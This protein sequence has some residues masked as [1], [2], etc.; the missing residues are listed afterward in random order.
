MSALAVVERRTSLEGSASEWP[1]VGR[2]VEAARVAAAVSGVS[3]VGSGS[4]GG[5]VLVGSAG[6][7]KTALA[8]CCLGRAAG[9]GRSTLWL[10]GTCATADIPL[11]ALSTVLTELDGAASP[12]QLLHQASRAVLARASA[13]PLVLAVDDG[14]WLDD[15][16]ATLVAR[17]VDDRQ[18]VLV[19][20]IRAGIAVPDPLTALWKN[21]RVQRIELEPLDRADVDEV[22]A[23]ALGGPVD[24]AT[25]GEFRRVSDGNPLFLRELFLAAQSNGLLRMRDGAWTLT[26]PLPTSG[27]LAEL[28]ETRLA[29]LDEPARE[30]LEL[31][32]VGG[33]LRLNH[34]EGLASLDVLESLETAELL[35]VRQTAG[36]EQVE[37]AHPLFGE[38]LRQGLPNLR[39]RR[40]RQVLADALVSSAD[41]D[42]ADLERVVRWRL[43]AGATPAPEALLQVARRAL[44][45]FDVD[46]AHRCA[47]AAHA[48]APTAESALLYGRAAA[49]AG[50]HDEAERILAAGLALADSVQTTDLALARADNLFHWL[51]RPEA[52]RSVLAAAAARCSAQDAARIATRL[53]NYDQYDGRPL[54]A[55]R[56]LG[57][58]AEHPDPLAAIDAGCTGAIAAMSCGQFALGLAHLAV[59]DR[60]VAELG[61]TEFSTTVAGMD[62]ASR[63]AARMGIDLHRGRYGDVLEFGLRAHEVAVADSSPTARGWIA[64][65]L[66]AAYLAQGRMPEAVRWFREAV[67]ASNS[68]STESLRRV[69]LTGLAAAHAWAGDVDTAE[70]T[71]AGVDDLPG[72]RLPLFESHLRRARA[73]VLAGR[74]HTAEAAEEFIAAACGGLQSGHSPVFES[75]LLHDAIRV[76]PAAAARVADRLVALAALVEG[77]LTA[78]RARLATALADRDPAGAEAAAR[79]FEV[80]GATLFAAEAAQAGANLAAVAGSSRR[81]T[82]LRRYAAD[83]A[84]RCEGA[85]TP[86]LPRPQPDDTGALTEREAQIAALA[87]HGMSSK[88]IA[89]QL[90]LSPRTVDNCLGRVFVKLGVTSRSDLAEALA[91]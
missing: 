65:I 36:G 71:L 68:L 73:W 9:A 11:G 82:A 60:A 80:L 24:I 50:E 7:G 25:S 66:G 57:Q 34:L 33:A 32:A 87:A 13:R 76:D 12:D 42:E 48:A 88:A 23:A 38:V 79:E 89:A 64:H 10:T 91:I 43:A 47:G 56:S 19:A 85:A 70:N 52:G 44:T 30:A 8:R 40:L 59:A 51:D 15:L 72:R 26:G 20:T 86:G 16:T 41:L 77:P 45:R 22:L 81:A 35:T 37:L 75:A 39:A 29:G 62:L 67:D 2:T 90:Y 46:L 18:A 78:A 6:A 49:L 61:G 17:L 55:L 63:Y 54:E 31:L 74:G 5:V 83:L 58:P 53:A 84:S 21:G 69:V 1:L 27:R 14:Q 28:I 4:S 3:G